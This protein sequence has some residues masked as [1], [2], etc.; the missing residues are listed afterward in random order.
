[1]A[2]LAFQTKAKRLA[3]TTV[4]FRLRLRL[5]SDRLRVSLSISEAALLLFQTFES[6]T[7]PFP[8]ASCGCPPRHG[9]APF[10]WRVPPS[11]GQL[12]PNPS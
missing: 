1:M 8:L 6:F 2:A 3:C 9:R 5:Q 10:P 11:P 7:R 12:L 4:S